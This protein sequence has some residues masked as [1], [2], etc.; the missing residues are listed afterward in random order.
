[1]AT[2]SGDVAVIERPA[3]TRPA[4]ATP[5]S[6]SATTAKTPTI[7]TQ[8]NGPA[9]PVDSAANAGTTQPVPVEASVAPSTSSA[10]RSQ[11]AG[12]PPPLVSI[13]TLTAALDGAI[14]TL[15]PVA[16]GTSQAAAT[17][18]LLG[19]A[20]NF[21]IIGASTITNTG[22]STIS[23]DVGLSPGS[24]V[25]GFAPCTP[26][27]PANCVALTGALHVADGVALQAQTDQLT[28]YNSLVGQESS[29]TRIDVE[30]AGRTYLPG[31][32]CSAGTFNL[33]AGGILTLN[34]QGNPDAQFIFLTGAGGSTLI[35]GAAS[36]VLVTGSAQACNVYW[37][38]ASS[39][40]IGVATRF[41]GHILA[42]Q[43]I[44]LQTGATLQGSAFAQKGAVTLDTN[45]INRSDCSTGSGGGTPG[46]GTPG[47][48]TPGGG[49]P[50]GGTPGGGTP[51]GGVLGGGVLGGGVLGGGVLG[52]GVLGGG[53]S[54]GGNPGGSTTSGSSDTGLVTTGLVT[55][56][57]VTTGLV[58]TGLVT[59]GVGAPE[60][61]RSASRGGLA[62]TGVAVDVE[63]LLAGMVVGV[64]GLMV[65]L[66]RR[67]R[68]R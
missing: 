22:L 15:L 41:V 12:A 3:A 8:D 23:G 60:R 9:N 45:T 21:A 18:A 55:T 7:S 29:C 24:A 35:T 51:G 19:T 14:G 58:T 13:D 25:T 20:G 6:S 56:G 66:G 49:T 26:P 10:T 46:G 44:Q 53:T 5:S 67:R 54:A 43:S 65:G 52:G 40:T 2:G 28:A 16:A 50:G 30:L 62:R 34:A 33:S 47:G 11:A 1:V 59:T 27:A 63:L 39:A 17:P 57:L 64:G 68:A 48:G 36:Q 37:Q 42:S 38:V 31:T 4:T 32:Y 61:E